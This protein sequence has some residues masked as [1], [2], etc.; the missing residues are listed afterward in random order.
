[1]SKVTAPLLSFDAAGQI[2]DT[3]VYASWKGRPYARK[4]VV[5]SNPNSAGQQLTRNT[6]SYLSRLWQYMPSGAK[7]AWDLYANNSRFTAVNGFMK[8][9]VGVLRSQTDLQSMIMS[10]AANGGIVAAGLALTAGS[11]QITADLTAPSLPSGWTIDNAWAMAI[12][13][14]DPQTSA[15]YDVTSGSDNTDPY[16]IVLSGLTASQQYVVGGWFE[17]TRDSGDKAY[18]LAITDVATPTA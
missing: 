8:Q 2:A 3:L 9:N 7:G 4:Y 18:G 16:S 6:F 1:M 5:P 17:Y 13:D 10:P 15:V 11:L 12:S 14:E